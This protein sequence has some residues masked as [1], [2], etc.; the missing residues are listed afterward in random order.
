MGDCQSLGDCDDKRIGRIY[1]YLDGALSCQDLAD[2]KAHLDDCPDCTQEYD[3]ECVIRSVVKRSCKEAAPATL[4]A[5]I[6]ARL[7][8]G[9][10]AEV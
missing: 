10:P 6:L 5:A 1:E 3:L 8:E 7:H 9:R 4:K 2:I